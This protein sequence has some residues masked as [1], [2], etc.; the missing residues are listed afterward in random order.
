M[1]RTDAW[2]ARATTRATPERVID[3]LTDARACARWSPIPFTVD[4]PDGRLRAGTTTRVSGRLLG[5]RVR[6]EIATLAANRRGLRLHARGPIDIHVA[7]TLT[8]AP[9]GCAV[10]ALV[11]V[12]P[13][14]TPH[15]RVLARATRMLLATGTLDHA[16]RR[17]A[18]EAEHAARAQI[19][20]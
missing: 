10:D 8:P 3:A 18:R 19:H 17:I 1:T 15:G 2:R 9:M 20:A 12:P 11:A 13:A 4:D 5:A 16:V 14:R 7:Y 6:F